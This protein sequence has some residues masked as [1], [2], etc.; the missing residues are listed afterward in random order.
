MN[1]KQFLL[2]FDTNI[3]SDN[4]STIAEIPCVA[5]NKTNWSVVVGIYNRQSPDMYTSDPKKIEEKK[6]R[7]KEEILRL[8]FT[9]EGIGAIQNIIAEFM[10]MCLIR[11]EKGLRAKNKA[12]FDKQIR[13]GLELA[14]VKE[15]FREWKN[16]N[17]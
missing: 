2:F 1:G 4:Y 8:D 3:L 15:K 13:L 17:E 11:A 9:P 6:E 5:Q 16:W 14:R 10:V 7:D 12:A